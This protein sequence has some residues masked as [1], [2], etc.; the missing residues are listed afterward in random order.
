MVA[1]QFGSFVDCFLLHALAVDFKNPVSRF[2]AGCRRWRLG[3]D[4]SHGY[5][6]IQ[7][8]VPRCNLSILLFVRLL[9]VEPKAVVA[10]DITAAEF[11]PRNQKGIGNVQQTVV[12]LRF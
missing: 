1:N 5:A 4:V 9:V 10:S 3:M 6:V 7:S 8:K 12:P 2:E 11:S